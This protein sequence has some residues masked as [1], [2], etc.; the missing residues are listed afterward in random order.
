MSRPP[1]PIDWLRFV[2][3]SF[4]R[5]RGLLLASSL[6]YTTVL[7][8]VPLLA[9]AFS[10][11]KGFGIYD[12]PFLRDVLLRLTAE[13]TDIVD[14]VLGY[15][16]NTNVKALGI[17]G[18]AG[19]LFTS[20]GLLSTMEEAFNI[21]WHATQPRSLWN[22]FTNYTTVI[23]VCPLFILAAFSAT[24]SVQSASAVQWM[25]ETEI[26][27]TALSI[28]LKCVPLAMV[29]LSLFIVYSFLP[30]VRVS[31][32]ASAVGALI[33]GFFWQ[34]IQTLYIKYQIG[35]TGY[36]AIYGSFAQIPLLLVWLY[37]SWLIVLAGA[38]I[39]Y[40]LQYFTRLRLE[41]AARN[42][43]V[44][45]RRGLALSLAVLLAG[46]AEQRLPPL[47]GAEAAGELGVAISAVAEELQRLARIGVAVQVSSERTPP[48]YVLAGAPDKFAMEEIVL[49]WEA[50]RPE[51]AAHSPPIGHPALETIRKELES[52]RLEG[53]RHTLRDVWL[54]GRTAE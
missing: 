34:S 10:V 36:N 27:N 6:S 9:V 11:S 13:K 22:R 42:F 19:L 46:R 1:L 37:I 18:V 25:R 33:A 51:G 7:S 48:A 52:S 28:A 29:S 21:I 5:N 12:A 47:D 14:T 40:A 54:S 38:E 2:A 53:H 44:T 8:L 35:V 49:A 3:E 41:D 24:A 17:I 20:V 43:S 50:L 26:L 4:M 45:D 30:N 39:A 16:Q 15:I 23:L 32:F 31:F